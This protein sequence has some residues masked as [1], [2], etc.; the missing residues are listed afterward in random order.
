MPR[1]RRNVEV[2]D[3]TARKLKGSNR[4]QLWAF[5]VADLA[6]VLGETE[7]WVRRKISF[8]AIDPSTLRGLAE[9]MRGQV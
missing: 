3:L 4:T 7:D 2:S 5:G 6:E 9:A 8:G 1:L